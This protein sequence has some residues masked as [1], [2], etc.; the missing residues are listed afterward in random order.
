MKMIRNLTAALVL[1]TASITGSQAADFEA[2][3][4]TLG[5]V[6]G[7]EFPYHTSALYMKDLMAEASGN[8][9]K[10]EIHP[11]GALGGERD[12]LDALLLGT[13]DFTWVH[14]AAM[15][16]FAPSFDLFNMPFVFHSPAHIQEALDTLDFSKFYE[17][18]DAAGFKLLG[19]G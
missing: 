8:K 12:A 16:S 3:D 17:E 18:A 10:L 9:W 11:N 2:R 14:T 6:V 5:H 4:F 15:A 19:I 13:M 1:A 7:P